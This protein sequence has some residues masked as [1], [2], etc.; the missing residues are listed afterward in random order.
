MD[1]EVPPTLGTFEPAAPHGGPYQFRPEETYRVIEDARLVRGKLEPLELKMEITAPNANPANP[2]RPDP[3]RSSPP[4]PA[5]VLVHGGGFTRGSP[6]GLRALAVEMAKQGLV[7]VNIAYRLSVPVGVRLRSRARM[8]NGNRARRVLESRRFPAAVRDVKAAVRRTRWEIQRGVL[9]EIGDASIVGVCGSSAG[10]TLAGTVAVTD[11]ARVDA[12]ALTG[13]EDLEGVREEHVRD[14]VIS[15]GRAGARSSSGRR[16]RPGQGTRGSARRGRDRFVRAFS[17]AADFAAMIAGPHVNLTVQ[18]RHGARRGED[19][20][21]G[22][23]AYVGKRERL[24]ASPISYLVTGPRGERVPVP[25]RE[26]DAELPEFLLFHGGA[27]QTVPFRFAEQ[28]EALIASGGGAARLE[29]LGRRVQHVGWRRHLTMIAEDVGDLARLGIS[30]A[31]V[32]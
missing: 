22:I 11:P 29:R 7:C 23:K 24:A 27:D 10:A 3:E 20:S 31:P 4:W 21:G 6:R 18:A 26:T 2:A 15:T 13:V 12:K 16:G 17:S 32:S 19:R 9:S 8:R 1:H 25:R 30:S 5:L 28:N 14:V